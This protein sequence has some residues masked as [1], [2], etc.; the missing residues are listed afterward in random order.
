[1]NIHPCARTCA[2]G[3]GLLA[4][5]ILKEGWTP[6]RAAVIDPVTCVPGA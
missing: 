4:E 6:G 1:M 5:R 3:R 2:A